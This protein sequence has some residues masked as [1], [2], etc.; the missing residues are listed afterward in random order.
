[1][2]L[3]G[4]RFLTVGLLVVGAAACSSVQNYSYQ[5]VSPVVETPAACR[6]SPRG[7]IRLKADGIRF[8]SSYNPLGR[9]PNVEQELLVVPE[10]II[11]KWAENRFVTTGTPDVQ[12]RFIIRDASIT[13][14]GIVTGACM[15]EIK[16]EYTGRFEVTIQFVD[17]N[18]MVLVEATKAVQKSEITANDLTAEE[19]EDELTLLTYRLVKKLSDEL[20]K[21]LC[22]HSFNDYIER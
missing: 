2:L 20:D 18:G 3:K 6:I 17:A 13:G 12:V 21:D 11:H 22:S 4:L 8:I 1:M 19:R 14:R 7:K 9:A 10:Q 15:K 5:E 16:A